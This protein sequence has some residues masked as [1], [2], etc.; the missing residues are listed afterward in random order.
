MVAPFVRQDVKLL[1]GIRFWVGF[2]EVAEEEMRRNG[3]GNSEECNI[4]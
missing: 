3:K 1:A 2:E 4:H